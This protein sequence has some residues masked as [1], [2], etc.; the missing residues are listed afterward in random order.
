MTPLIVQAG[1]GPARSFTGDFTAGRRAGLEIPDQYA[2]PVHARFRQEAAG[3]FV[4]DMGST[5][6]TWLNGARVY[7]PQ[8]LARGDKIRIGRTMLTVVPA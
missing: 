6:G 8:R 5:N 2:S 3:W 4:E 1:D 7:G